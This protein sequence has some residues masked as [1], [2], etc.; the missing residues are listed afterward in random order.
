MERSRAGTRRKERPMVENRHEKKQKLLE[1]AQATRTVLAGLAVLAIL[2]G[3][4]GLATNTTVLVADALH[5]VVD[6][7][8]VSSVYFGLKLATRPPSQRF[9][10]GYYKAESLAALFVSLVILYGGVSLGIE[11]YHHLH[12]PEV[13]EYP[14]AALGVALASGIA[15]YYL[16][17]YE[18]EIGKKTG[19]HAMETTAK[20]A[21]MD[22]LSSGL[23]FLAIL[24]S[25]LG[26]PLVEG[27]ATIVIALVI[28]KLAIENAWKSILGLMDASPDPS[29]EER[30]KKIIGKTRGVKECTALKLRSA[31]PFIFG[32][33]T[34]RVG[35][36]VDVD[37]AHEIADEIEK[38]VLSSEPRIETITIHVEPYRP[39]V[40]TLAIPVE[41][42]KDLDS[43]VSNHFARAR[44]FLL[45]RVDKNKKKARVVE[46]LENPHLETKIRAGLAVAKLLST[47]NIDAIATREIGEISF[48]TLRDS[49]VNVYKIKGV[50]AR[51]VVK[52]FMEEKLEP[53][54]KPTR[55][56]E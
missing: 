35:K 26:M 16:S 4:V 22:V 37:R 21:M 34:I 11:G 41:E 18:H 45:V 47:K 19:S 39:N 50:T 42:C 25:Y 23:V 17:R 52:N 53:L 9:P 32:E 44:A 6:L 46:C 28:T 27:I 38:R 55:K 12:T 1:G 3:L 13:I 36:N 30:I 43:R 33:A 49:L 54:R 40:E 20:E 31:G 24:L 2:K 8:A 5:S 56:K 14:L 10:Y 29:L 48:H 7:V 51:D 15:C